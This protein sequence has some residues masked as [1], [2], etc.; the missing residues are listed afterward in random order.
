MEGDSLPIPLVSDQHYLHKSGCDAKKTVLTINGM[1][2][3]IEISQIHGQDSKKVGDSDGGG[4][5]MRNGN[6]EALEEA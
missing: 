6:K 4:N 2:T 1:S 3:W 5:A